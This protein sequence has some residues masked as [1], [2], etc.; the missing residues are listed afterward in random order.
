MPLG[1][2]GNKNPLGFMFGPER[3]GDPA[4]E[5]IVVTKVIKGTA[6]DGTVKVG[7]TVLGMNEQMCKGPDQLKQVIEDA[8]ANGL[9][10]VSNG[11]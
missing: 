9:M 4:G 5:G 7:D 1:N 3:R 10:E 2:A 11:K 8:A 6:A